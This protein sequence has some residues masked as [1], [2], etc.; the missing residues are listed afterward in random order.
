[1][2]Q[3]PLSQTEWEQQM[4]ARILERVRATLYLDL[5]YLNTALGALKP[6]PLPDLDALFAT[7]GARLCYAPA[8]L[9]QLYRTN[10]RYP[11]RALL[12]TVLHCIFRHPWL[13]GK[14]DAALWGLA[15]DLVVEQVIDEMATPG[16]KRPVGWLRQ[17][18]YRTLTTQC[19]PLA[20]GPVYRYL[21]G[22]D[23][24]ALARLQQEFYC[25]SHRFW[26]DDP[27][28]PQA[29]AQGQRWEQL[30]RQTQ[31]ALQ[32]AGRSAS[33]NS[34]ALEAQ[35]RAGQS[36]RSYADFLRRFAVWREEPRLDPDT[37][38]P[39]FYAYGL[40]VYGNLPLLEPL[41]TRE[42]K[43]IREFAIVL[44]TSESTS[45]TLI[46]N[47]LKETFTLLK[48]GESFF[49]HCRILVMQADDAVQSE[50]WLTDLDTVE[51]YAAHLTLR[52]GGGT[53]FA[54]ALQ[55]VAEL[56]QQGTLRDLQ[57]VLYFTDG[58]GRYPPR[59]PPFEVAFLFLEGDAPPPEVP[60]WAMKLQ[61]Q[62]EEF[63]PPPAPGPDAA[64][65]TLNRRV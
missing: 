33:Q 44:D 51:Q 35:V 52:G 46:R 19:K 63:L 60:P 8:H 40:R 18:T 11:P 32:Q 42:S 56:Q 29:Q 10:R 4:A 16:T 3:R 26:P 38:D 21:C 6:T 55:R 27:E 5:R 14:R 7:E 31:V 17:Q 64:A 65:A 15:C 2:P 49:R 12:H 34:G 25:D 28:S 48:S 57:G 30:G 53:D 20:A 59:R 22:L 23:A 50:V 1:M 47:F 62:P 43:K 61:L 54:P 9:V 58:R 41:E 36:R 24:A 39:G 45:G 37:F 13:R